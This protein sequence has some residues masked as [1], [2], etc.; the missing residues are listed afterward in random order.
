MRNVIHDR[1]PI[2]TQS[3]GHGRR[4][5]LCFQATRVKDV[6]RLFLNMVYMGVCTTSYWQTSGQLVQEINVC[7]VHVYEKFLQ[8]IDKK[9]ALSINPRH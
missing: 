5:D 1:T 8:V 3:P 4:D 9:N 2:A 7:T 6:L